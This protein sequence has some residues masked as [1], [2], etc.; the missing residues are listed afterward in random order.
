MLKRYVTVVLSVFLL[1]SIISFIMWDNHVTKREVVYEGNR[2]M[3]SVDGG[4]VARFPSSGNYYLTN[5]DCDNKNTV[6]LWDNEKHN[7]VVSNG[8]HKSGV[9]CYLTLESKPKL[10]SMASGSYVKYVGDNGCVGKLCSGQN[11]NY[12]DNHHLG[13]CGSKDLQFSTDGYRIAYVN[14]GSAYLV[15]AGSP[16]C[17]CSSSD[18]GTN[19]SCATSLNVDSVS[20]HIQNLNSISLKYCNP[21]FVFGGECN[22]EVVRNINDVDYGYMVLPN[23]NLSSCVGLQSGKCGYFD[24]LIDIG[25]D[26]WYSSLYTGVNNVVFYWNS[27]KRIIDK[28]VSSSAFG[29]RPII[30]MD[31]DVIVIG[32]DGSYANPYQIANN[33]FL[34]G[35]QDSTKGT[36][37]LKMYGYQVK[38]M[39]V[40][41]N[42][43]VCT[44]YVPFVDDYVLD[45]SNAFDTENVIYVYYKDATGNIISVINRKFV[46]KK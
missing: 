39:C 22:G 21:Q 3:V 5:Y 4:K 31:S 9:S 25:S 34:V 2:F 42:S 33:T 20:Q 45:I 11:A 14:D 6:V 19:N 8:N 40:N 35:D 29:I 18:G 17:I 37:H 24:D 7:V 1:I 41:L 27:A 36:I 23:N 38:E 43:T 26:Y 30:R 12:V 16:E 15:S 46:L 32:G 44:H 28:S 10:S 13:Y